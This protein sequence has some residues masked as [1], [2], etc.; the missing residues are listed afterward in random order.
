MKKVKNTA[1]YK[2]SIGQTVYHVSQDALPYMRECPTCLG[3]GQIYR[4]DKSKISCP[5]CL[6]K[7][8]ISTSGS[9]KWNVRENKISGIIITGYETDCGEDRF[10]V[11]Y[12]LEKRHIKDIHNE[13]E[14]Y[15]TFKEAEKTIPKNCICGY[16]S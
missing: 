11:S 8:E 6:G 10:D 4:K 12:K 7:K 5:T 1:E 3:G 16:S 13:Y 15:K 2:Y 9:L 14:L